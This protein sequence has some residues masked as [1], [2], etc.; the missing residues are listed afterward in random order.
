MTEAPGVEADR[1]ILRTVTYAGLF[2]FPVP[3]PRLHRGLMDVPLDLAG[4]RNRLEAPFLRSRIALTE[5]C[6]H[7]RGREEWI[8]LREQRRRHTHALLD[9]HRRVLRALA[10]FPWVRLAALSGGCAHENATDDDVDVFLVAKRGRAWS[11]SLA[12]M[13][14]SKLLGLRRTLCLN[15]V[16]DEAALAL[17]E[18]DL[19]TAAEIVGMKPLAG[20][21]AYRRFV[22]ANTWAAR[23]FPNFFASFEQEAADVPAVRRPARLERLLDAAVGPLLEA[24]S[25]RVLGAY[26]RR[27]TAGQPGVDLTPHRLKLHTQ[28]HRP[29]LSELF[30]QAV[31]GAEQESGRDA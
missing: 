22:S 30:S 28:D 2:R 16:V 23:R 27:K 24:L 13:A 11:L 4:L 7:P 26:L 21:E 6:V 18:N 17:P 3:L 8:R 19:F 31:R 5:G 10:G 14:L 9:R 15:Y 12:L 1:A 29:R 25:R 20:R